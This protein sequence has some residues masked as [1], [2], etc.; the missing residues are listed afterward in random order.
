MTMIDARGKAETEPDKQVQL[1]VE[2]DAAQKF[3][4]VTCPK[5]DL[6]ESGSCLL[7]FIIV[8]IVG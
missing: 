6:N 1:M 4:K 7:M 8:V 5:S 3:T 2:R